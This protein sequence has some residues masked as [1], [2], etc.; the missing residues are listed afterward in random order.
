MVIMTIVIGLD[1]GKRWV[2]WK[3][4]LRMK[5]G[6]FEGVTYE[7]GSK[8]IYLTRAKFYILRRMISILPRD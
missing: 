3:E 5:D 6:F 1:M 2:R 8:C 4:G 7:M